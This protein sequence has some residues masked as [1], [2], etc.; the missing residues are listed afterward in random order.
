M[1]ADDRPSFYRW[2]H[3]LQDKRSKRY[4]VFLPCIDEFCNCPACG[5]AGS[6]RPAY[7]AMYLT[8]IDLTPYVKSDGTEIPFTKKLLV[9]K[10][11]QQKK[12]M[13]YFERHGTLRGMVLEMTRD[14]DKDANIGDPEYV[15]HAPEEELA[16]YVSEY[17]DKDGVVHPIYCDEPYPYEELFPPMDE[18]QLRA[19]VGGEAPAGSRAADN[20]A[21]G[22]VPRQAD[23]Y[24]DG[25]AG[26]DEAWGGQGRRVASRRAPAADQPEAEQ[27]E[28]EQAQP[29]RTARTVRTAAAPAAT[30][31]AVRPAAAPAAPARAVRRPQQ[32][33]IDPDDNPET[34]ADETPPFDTGTPQRTARPVPARRV[35]PAPAP[36]PEDAAPAPRPNMAARRQNL[37]R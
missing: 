32:A 19:L 2:E 21:L 31:R 28:E 1:I 33:V 27:Y 17:T 4:D 7:F 12:I 15:E 16:D 25:A 3:A 11:M 37:R 14:G 6:N 35:A 22:R 8:V 26:G 29:A 30:A 18:D 20:R 24:D 23:N 10:P 5:V 36:E 9:V 34:G 13:R